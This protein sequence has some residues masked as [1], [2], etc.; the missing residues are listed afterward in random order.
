MYLSIIMITTP[1]VNKQITRIKNHPRRVIFSEGEDLRVLQVAAELVKQEIAAPIL[2]GDI[3]K[4]KD[5]AEAN[6]VSLKF[7]RIINPQT[8]EDLPLFAQYFERSERFRNRPISNLMET[9]AKPQNFACLMVQ[10]GAAD[11]V[12][13]GNILGNASMSRSAQLMVKPTHKN[14]TIFALNILEGQSIAKVNKQGLL[15]LSDTNVNPNPSVEDLIIMTEDVGKLAH[16]FLEEKAKV[17][18]LSHSNQGSFPTESSKKMQAATSF[19][20][21]RTAEYRWPIECFGEVQFD[22]AIDATAA[23]AKTDSLRKPKQADVL[24]FP[25]LDSAHITLKALE[26][27]G[28]LNVYGHLM[29]G[30]SRPVAIIPKTATTEQLFG[31]TILAATQSLLNRDQH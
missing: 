13:G 31:T 21:Q 5:L 28:N 1:F 23:A 19:I 14:H 7:I 11:V 10:Y 8:A 9:V 15:F 27:I 2:F 18:L 17:A 20:R 24:I 29:M 6:H 30:L 22:V 16:H 12:V 3:Q 4:I 26:H 25:N